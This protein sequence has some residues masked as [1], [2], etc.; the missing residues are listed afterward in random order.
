MDTLLIWIGRIAGL[1]GVALCAVAFVARAAHTWNLGSFNIGAI[2]QA[3]LAGMLLG[4]LAY[5]ARLAERSG[6]PR[7]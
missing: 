3:G 7:S 1:A 5:V 2:L 6:V 4:C